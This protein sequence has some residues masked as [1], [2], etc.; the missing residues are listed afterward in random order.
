MKTVLRRT[1][2]RGSVGGCK[3]QMSTVFTTTLKFFE[4]MLYGK[5]DD[6]DHFLRSFRATIGPFSLK[7]S[8]L[9]VFL[10]VIGHQ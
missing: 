9:I 4:V 7:Y 6:Q 3:Q 10:T 2:E 5:V 1:Q 8:E